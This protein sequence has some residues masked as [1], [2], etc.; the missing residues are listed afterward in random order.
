VFIVRAA[1][2]VH[3][4]MALAFLACA[5]FAVRDVDVSALREISAVCSVAS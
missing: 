5:L 3:A 4:A 2:V 1:A